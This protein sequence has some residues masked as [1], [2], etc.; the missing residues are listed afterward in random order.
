MKLTTLFC[1][2]ALC[3][4][5][6]VALPQTAAATCPTAPN[7]AGLMSSAVDGHDSVPMTE[8][9]RFDDLN[10]DGRDDLC[11]AFET[12]VRCHW[13]VIPAPSAT[14]TCDFESSYR[15]TAFNFNLTDELS[16]SSTLSVVDLDNDGDLD[17][18]A[19]GPDGIHCS[20][21][22][23]GGLFYQPTR[24]TTSFSDADGWD[25]ESHFSTLQFVDLNSDG[26]TDVCGR[27]DD[28]IHC[29]FSNGSTFVDA[30]IVTEPGDFSHNDT[31]AW[32]DWSSSPTL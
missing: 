22:Y 16:R 19:R 2:T 25:D 20:K 1:L 27:E 32:T 11:Y 18:C 5:A 3:A 31:R 26:R 9:V 23:Q 7:A 30:G 8:S 12:V 14:D 4:G 17:V 28:G 29:L 15:Q 13:R 21:S 24:W 10:N 6:V